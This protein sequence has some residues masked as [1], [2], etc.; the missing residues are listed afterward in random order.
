MQI[1][2][3]AQTLTQGRFSFCLILT[4]KT[5][6]RKEAALAITYKCRIP[7]RPEQSADTGTVG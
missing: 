1:S 3:L 5:L 6:Q 2:S 7:A 4:F